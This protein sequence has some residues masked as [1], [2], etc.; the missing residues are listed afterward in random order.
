MD[1]GWND[2]SGF[3]LYLDVFRM[4]L[5]WFLFLVFFWYGFWF[6]ICHWC[7]MLL[8]TALG[9]YGGGIGYHDSTRSTSSVR[10][11]ELFRCWSKPWRFTPLPSQSGSAFRFLVV[12]IVLI[13]I[14]ESRV[15]STSDNTEQVRLFWFLIVNSKV[16][17]AVGGLLGIE[18][19]WYFSSS[20]TGKAFPLLMLIYFYFWI[21]CRMEFWRI[22]FRQCWG[23][24][25]SQVFWGFGQRTWNVW[26]Y[27]RILSWYFDAY[28]ELGEPN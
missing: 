28:S 21:N 26:Y 20:N 4:C 13:L 17:L 2:T 23:F 6:S 7:Q 22:L 27:L 3:T 15:W 10:L 8:C 19:D 16:I 9:N 18:N 1:T 11:F 14:K 12:W 24:R 5:L 25:A